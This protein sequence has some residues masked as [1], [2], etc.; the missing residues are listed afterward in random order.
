[1]SRLAVI[2]VLVA[3][4]LFFAAPAGA[5]SSASSALINQQLDK[6]TS[7]EIRE[8]ILPDVM[9]YITKQTNVP[10]DAQADVWSI[11]PWGR[12]TVVTLKIENQTLREALEVLTRKLGL[13]FVLKDEAI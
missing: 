6:L 9:A 8:K 3:A 10:I 5:Q 11:L 2:G 12:E 1:M 7:L 4:S 13:Q